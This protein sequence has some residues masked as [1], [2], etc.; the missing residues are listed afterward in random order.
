MQSLVR[1]LEQSMANNLQIVSTPEQMIAEEACV[2]NWAKSIEPVM[3]RFAVDYGVSRSVAYE[4][5][6][7]IESRLSRHIKSHRSRKHELHPIKRRSSN[8][9][10]LNYIMCAP[11]NIYY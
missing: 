11:A 9:R 6:D 1:G 2:R 7:R 10:A 8:F 4:T 5:C 3:A